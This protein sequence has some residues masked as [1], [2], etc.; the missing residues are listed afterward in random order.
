MLL[1]Y[2]F[3]DVRYYSTPGLD[4]E[5]FVLLHGGLDCVLLSKHGLFGFLGLLL[6]GGM[7]AVQ[8]TTIVNRLKH[9]G[10]SSFGFDLQ[11][12][13]LVLYDPK[14]FQGLP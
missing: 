9:S 13:E 3:V 14:P 7:H 5:L 12:V 11:L 6:R 4:E 10:L 2:Q 8:P 1:D